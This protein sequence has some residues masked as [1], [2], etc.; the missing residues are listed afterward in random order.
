MP[1]TDSAAE[2]A[3]RAL[4]RGLSFLFSI[5]VRGRPSALRPG[6]YVN[7]GKKKEEKALR[8]GREAYPS[9]VAGE[10]HV[11]GADDEAVDGG[12]FQGVTGLERFWTL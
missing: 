4:A 1:R 11:L 3:S 2:N 12:A 7:T 6:S 9:S 5:F 8:S 10:L